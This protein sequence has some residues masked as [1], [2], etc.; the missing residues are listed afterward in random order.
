MTQRFVYADNVARAFG[1]DYHQIKGTELVSL[2]GCIMS[3]RIH[4]LFH[5]VYEVYEMRRA[6]RV[7]FILA[8]DDN[9]GRRDRPELT[10]D[11]THGSVVCDRWLDADGVR[12]KFVSMP[13][14][15]C[16]PAVAE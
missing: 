16:K 13:I 8:E 7:L 15:T 1:E 14:L 9:F 11:F 12:T 6:D 10:Y 5:I 4:P 3:E 2:D